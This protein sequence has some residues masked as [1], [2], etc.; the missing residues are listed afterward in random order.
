MRNIIMSNTHADALKR[1]AEEAAPEESCA[2]LLG[3]GR[4]VTEVVLA[5]NT[6]SNPERFFT[7][8]SEQLME[9]YR[10]AAEH[11]LEVVGIFHSHPASAA[12]PS[13]TDVTFM[14]TNPVVWAIYSVTS[15]ELRAYA[16]GDRNGEECI[17]DVEIMPDHGQPP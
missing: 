8:S 15:R 16:L 13:K 10:S 6:D 3:Y 7:V 2:L 12:R 14:R 17:Q 11:G 9:S 4:R 5:D 1:H